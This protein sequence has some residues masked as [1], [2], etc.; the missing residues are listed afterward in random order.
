MPTH[1]GGMKTEEGEA[2]VFVPAKLK[3]SCNLRVTR[4]IVDRRSTVKPRGLNGKSS[5]GNLGP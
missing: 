2:Y 3:R 1:D 5:V 4:A